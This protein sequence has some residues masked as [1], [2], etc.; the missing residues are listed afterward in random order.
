MRQ[1]G[2]RALKQKRILEGSRRAMG[3]E[4]TAHPTTVSEIRGYD[5]RR[6]SSL[7]LV[8]GFFLRA[9]LARTPSEL[10]LW[11]TILLGEVFE[12]GRFDFGLGTAERLNSLLGRS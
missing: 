10:C 3:G 4:H 8:E 6:R 7:L 9:R 2:P 1:R 12:E 5:D 11:N